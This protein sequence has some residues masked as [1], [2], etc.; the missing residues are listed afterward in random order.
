MSFLAS[1]N[2]KFQGFNHDQEYSTD[3]QNLTFEW[4]TDS[5]IAEQGFR[6]ILKHKDSGK[7]TWK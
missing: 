7:L 1:F 2:N 4:F 3:M 6:V 5:M